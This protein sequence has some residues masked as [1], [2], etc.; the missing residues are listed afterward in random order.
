MGD[1]CD[2]ATPCRFMQSSR[3]VVKV[4]ERRVVCKETEK[5]KKYVS[6]HNESVNRHLVTVLGRV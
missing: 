2:Q 3:I 4:C 6:K 5:L 1:V